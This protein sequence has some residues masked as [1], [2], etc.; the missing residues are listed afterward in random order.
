[1]ASLLLKREYSYFAAL[2][3]FQVRI[4]DKRTVPLWIGQAKTVELPEGLRTLGVKM[5]WCRSAPFSIIL[6]KE[7]VRSVVVSA[8]PI[9]EAMLGVYVPPFICFSIREV[10]EVPLPTGLLGLS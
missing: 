8:L 10:S 4:D 7:D 6:G 2:R 3:T 5:A 1:M 9:F